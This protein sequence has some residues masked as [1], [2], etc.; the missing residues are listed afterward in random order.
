MKGIFFFF[1]RLM[2]FEVPTVFCFVLA[3]QWIFR[4]QPLF[5]DVLHVA[6]MNLGSIRRTAEPEKLSSRT[7]F[8]YFFFF[9]CRIAKTKT[10]RKRLTKVKIDWLEITKGRTLCTHFFL[11]WNGKSCMQAEPNKKQETTKKKNKFRIHEQIAEQRA[12]IFE[13]FTFWVRNFE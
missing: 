12:E 8:N 2:V 13:Y 4:I 7:I 9:F 10:T 11:L 3:K 1:F 5:S 6:C